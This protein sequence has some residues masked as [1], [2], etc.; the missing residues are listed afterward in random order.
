MD[1]SRLRLSVPKVS[2]SAQ[3]GVIHKYCI[4]VIYGKLEWDIHHRFSEFHSLN[5]TLQGM[6]NI[7]ALPPPPRKS[8]IR[9]HDAST[10]EERRI[11]LQNWIRLLCARPDVRTS[12]PFLEF[13]E[14]ERHTNVSVQPL[15]PFLCGACDDA[16]FQ[17]SDFI[18]CQ[19]T[20]SI[21]ASYEETAGMAR[22]GKVWSLVEAEELGSLSVWNIN[23]QDVGSLSSALYDEQRLLNPYRPSLAL[24][25]PLPS[26]RDFK[27][28]ELDRTVHMSAPYR[29]HCIFFYPP[30]NRL[31]AG[32]DTGVVQVYNMPFSTG[33]YSCDAPTALHGFTKETDLPLHTEAILSLSGDDSGCGR[34]ITT[35]FDKAI[36]VVNCSSLETISGG[37]LAKRMGFRE[38]LVAA[39]LERAI[40]EET[41]FKSR[42]FIGTS[43][44]N[45]FVY[46]SQ[47]NPPEYRTTISCKEPVGA[48]E[49]AGSNLLVAHKY[50]LSIYRVGRPGEETKAQLTAQLRPDLPTGRCLRSCHPML[51]V[52]KHSKFTI[53]F[54]SV[55]SQNLLSRGLTVIYV[56]L[57]ASISFFCCICLYHV[58]VVNAVSQHSTRVVGAPHFVYV[59]V[60]QVV[61]FAP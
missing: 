44:G 38:Q 18:W 60:L 12:S 24:N 58:N 45:V 61:R 59:F 56:L 51:G 46:A 14:F 13:I 50:T 53:C 21:V 55:T 23:E 37:N 48:L 26:S 31:F 36:R 2:M 19:D 15:A 20:R 6:C 9:P 57:D 7:Q 35:S 8:V 4:N 39:V 42:M 29:F 22:V 10:L 40:D 16:K 34:F 30:Q 27:E 47:V 28:L 11:M 41:Y 33:D 25:D 49:L 54:L 1:C 5:D 17:L 32:L 43:A 52:V 3:E